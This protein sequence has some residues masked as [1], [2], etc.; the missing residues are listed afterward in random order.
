MARAI[1]PAKSMVGA[2]D[3]CQFDARRSGTGEPRRCG[4]ERVVRAVIMSEARREIVPAHLPG[5]RTVASGG[6]SF[7]SSRARALASRSSTPEALDL[8]TALLRLEFGAC[9]SQYR[10]C[11]TYFVRVA[12]RREFDEPEFRKVVHPIGVT[13][14]SAG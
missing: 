13:D 9:G 5:T 10:V 12:G 2:S 14:L 8:G 3:R 6:P 11:F 1:A 7:A 4:N